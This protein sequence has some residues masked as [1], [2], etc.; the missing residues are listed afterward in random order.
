MFVSNLLDEYIL[1][2]QQLALS[3]DQMRNSPPK[4]PKPASSPHTANGAN[5]PPVMGSPSTPI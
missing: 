4:P 5:D 2:Q 3:L 1:A